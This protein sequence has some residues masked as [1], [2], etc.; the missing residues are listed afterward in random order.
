MQIFRLLALLLCAPLAADEEEGPRTVPEATGYR[1]TST[2]AQVL[3]FLDALAALPHGERLVRRAASAGDAESDFALP[4]VLAGI[5]A[6]AEARRELAA[7][8]LRVLV[9]ADI[10]GGEVEGKEAV[11]E[12]L[13]EIAQGRHEELLESAA[14]VFV[15][16]LNAAG[17]DRIDRRNRVSQNG[18]EGGVGERANGQG[19]DLNRDFVKLDAPECRALVGLLAAWDPHLFMDLHATNGS[20][21]GYH[22]TYA[23]SLSTSVDPEL[24]AFARDELLPEIRAAVLQRHGFRVFDYGN[25]SRRGERSWSTY[26]HRPRFGTNYVG[27]RNRLGVLAEAYSYRSFEQ[28][29]AVTRA[30][31]LETVGRAAARADRIRA[32]C[33]AADERVRQGRASLHWDTRLAAGERAPVLVGEI[34]KVELEGLGTRRVAADTWRAETMIVRDRFTSEAS[35]PLPHGYALCDPSA[36]TR[37]TLRRHGVLIEELSEDRELDVEIFSPAEISRSR[38]PFQGHHQI[39]LRGDWRPDRRMFPRGTWV[40][41]TRQPLGRLVAQLLDPRSE[42]SLSTWG[43]FEA[44]IRAA[45]G[46]GE[47]SYPVLRLPHD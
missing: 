27:L 46:E 20:T 25:F 9:N 41:T 40:V 29:I 18:P 47:G 30:F 5:P 11:L 10:H 19:L 12:L 1:Q 38:R 31:V 7:D 36:A 3:E 4:I 42:D 37:A 32:L 13:R 33:A 28:R 2:S 26:D 23:P 24:D 16:V 15:P 45:D 22:L 35:E 8:R 39:A 6:P 44:G 14:I 34:S 21:H 43:F 17:N